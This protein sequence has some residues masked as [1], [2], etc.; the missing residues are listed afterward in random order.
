MKLHALLLASTCS[1]ALHSR[2]AV[3]GWDGDSPGNDWT[4]GIAGSDTNWTG[5]VFPAPTDDVVIDAPL[6]ADGGWVCGLNDPLT[7]ASITVGD[8]FVDPQTSKLSVSDVIG[9]TVTNG[10]LVAAGAGFQ[11]EVSLF[12]TAATWG[13][14]DIASAA[15]SLGRVEVRDFSDVIVNSSVIIGRNGGEGTLFIED[16]HFETDSVFVGNDA[17][18]IGYLETSN[19][20]LT[21]NDRFEVGVFGS[22]NLTTNNTITA[23]SMLFGIFEGA[24]GSG[25]SYGTTATLAGQLRVGVQ[26]GADYT[27]SSNCDFTIT[28]PPGQVSIAVGEFASSP[29]SRLRIESVGESGYLFSNSFVTTNQQAAIGILA[30]NAT[31]DMTKGRAFY[32]KGTGL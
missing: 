4:G 19:S 15:N 29:S 25:S 8:L 12:D 27:I 10:L 14:L 32:D 17:S 30:T 23:N 26:G 31:L 11:G 13:F 28:T 24:N 2:A 5:D 21:V 20:R 9:M 18:S 16:S 22:G 7:V 6:F 1:L 3:I